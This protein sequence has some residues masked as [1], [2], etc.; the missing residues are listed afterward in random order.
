MK[1]F[2]APQFAM[3]PAVIILKFAIRSPIGPHGAPWAHWPLWAHG[4][5]W[6]PW[7]PWG[8][9]SPWGPMGPMGPFGPLGPHGPLGPFGLMGP[10]GPHGPRQRIMFAPDSLNGIIKMFAVRACV[11]KTTIFSMFSQFAL[12]GPIILN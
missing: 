11:L 9:L 3:E 6:A 5:P 10:M 8:P 2:A 4:A 7:A 1:L 12:V